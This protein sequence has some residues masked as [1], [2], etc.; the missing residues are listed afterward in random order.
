MLLALDASTAIVSLA[1]CDGPAVLA[2]RS[3]S[4]APR[5]SAAL[6]DAVPPLLA[7]AG[8]GFADLSAI[9]VGRGPG[10]Y[11]GL[12]VALVATRSWALPYS[13]PVWTA[14]TPFATAARLFRDNPALESL[15]LAGPVRRGL[16]WLLTCRRAAPGS[17]L[18]APVP[19]PD[20]ESSPFSIV[21]SDALADC[22]LA[23]SP[24]TPPEAADLAFLHS[25]GVPGDPL[26]P[27]YL[28][29][30]VN[31]APRFDPLTG[32]PVA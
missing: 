18:P 23:L 28:H 13:V 6:I 15:S 21:A 30:P 11:T 19:V 1:L 2:S 32:A 31:I 5:Q 17:P 22:S 3:I 9:A 25:L 10:S 20:A 14:P 8:V 7:S 4:L 24:D 16:A 26:T 29:P 27:L 12:R